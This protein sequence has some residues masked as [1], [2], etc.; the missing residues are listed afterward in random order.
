MRLVDGRVVPVPDPYDDPRRFI[1]KGVAAVAAE[2]SATGVWPAR[3][4]RIS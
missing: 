1:R 3:V 4:V 2:R